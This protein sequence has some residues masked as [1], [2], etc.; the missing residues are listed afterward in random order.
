LVS[1]NSVTELPFRAAANRAQRLCAGCL[2]LS[3]GRHDGIRIGFLL[4]LYAALAEKERSLISSRTK[5]ALAAAKVRGQVLGNPRLAEARAT[6]NAI[7]TARA[8]TFAAAIAPA[9]REAQAAGAKSLRQIAA[10]LNAR[11]IAT[12]RGGKWEA[13]TV[14]NALKRIAV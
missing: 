13:A 11:G 5:A 2:G 9:I 1:G 10:A 3:N 12:A 8:D 6:V 4:H 14:A 7:R